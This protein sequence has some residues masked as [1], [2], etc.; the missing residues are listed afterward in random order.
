MKLFDE[1]SEFLLNVVSVYCARR[2]GLNKYMRI[3]YFFSEESLYSLEIEK[4]H[5][6]KKNQTKIQLICT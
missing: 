6:V 5:T 1:G 4:S 3:P 2:E